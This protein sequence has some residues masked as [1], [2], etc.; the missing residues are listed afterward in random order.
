MFAQVESNHEVSSHYTIEL[1]V[2]VVGGLIVL[3][4]WYLW[5]TKLRDRVKV[6]SA[7][8]KSQKGVSG[9]L[10]LY[11]RLFPDDGTNY[12]SEE[13]LNFLA[14]ES[15]KRQ[16]THAQVEDFFLVATV[17]D[18]VVGFLFCHYYPE[19]KYAI[20]NGQNFRSIPI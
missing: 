10:E 5:K 17:R 2:T 9:M 20:I 14:D 15:G 12:S 16:T 6:K 7:T 11:S 18:E 3:A 4:L 19:I 13:I 8:K 1:F